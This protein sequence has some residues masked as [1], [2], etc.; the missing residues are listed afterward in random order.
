[1]KLAIQ[2]LVIHAPADQVFEH[3]VDPALFGLWMAESAT[4]EPTPGG[5]VTWTHPNGDTVS[6][7][8]VVV[9]RPRRLVFTYGWE[10][11]EV[12]IPPGSTTVEVD[13]TAQDDGTTLVTLVHRGLDDGAADAHSD[14]W[15]H[16][17]DR[18]RR[19]AEGDHVGPDPWTDRRVPT[20]DELAR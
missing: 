4:L 19:T 16:Y 7:Q 20:P 14:G 11:A 1:V 3:F 12:Q 10:R 2:R 8:F 5:I 9:D 13:L 15:A 18:L 17:L 6:G